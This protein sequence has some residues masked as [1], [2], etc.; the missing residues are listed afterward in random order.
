MLVE[1]NSYAYSLRGE[2][3]LCPLL[4]SGWGWGK[5]AYAYYI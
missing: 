3:F 4:K 5:R 1:E 2:E